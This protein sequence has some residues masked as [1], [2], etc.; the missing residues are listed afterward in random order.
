MICDDYQHNTIKRKIFVECKL[1]HYLCPKCCDVNVIYTNKRER[2]LKF[3]KLIPLIN[4][5]NIKELIDIDRMKKD[6]SS[7]NDVLDN[8]ENNKQKLMELL[9]FA[10]EN[11]YYY[12]YPEI[13]KSLCPICS[14][15]FISNSELI[16]FII[17]ENKLQLEN[18]E[19]EYRENTKY[20][21]EESKS[22]ISYYFAKEE[23]CRHSFICDI[24]EYSQII[25]KE[26]K[27]E[28]IEFAM[29]DNGHLICENCCDCLVISKPSG[30]K[31]DKIISLI[32]VDNISEFISLGDLKNIVTTENIDDLKNNR[33]KL[34]KLAIENKCY[35]FRNRSKYDSMAIPFHLCPI[36][37][38]KRIPDDKLLLFILERYN[39][40]LKEIKKKYRNTYQ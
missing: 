28:K 18:I 25:C 27:D 36:C 37:T 14:L 8:V 34:L 13:S 26:C 6:I 2:M 32:N 3:Q 23:L 19:K 10:Y 21:T 7:Y 35:I 16:K 33:E 17:R 24:C 22:D 31:M 38:L 5:D 15:K 1:C 9:E 39:L 40:N 30:Q 20:N 12:E 11:D 29:C 4:N